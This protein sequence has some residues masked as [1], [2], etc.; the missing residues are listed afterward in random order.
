MFLFTRAEQN[1]SIRRNL[2]V[3]QAEQLQLTK[4]QDTNSVMMTHEQMKLTFNTV[5]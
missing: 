1:L 2:A 4:F 3:V 5:T